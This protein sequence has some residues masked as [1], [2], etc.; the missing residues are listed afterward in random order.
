MPDV[1]PQLMIDDGGRTVPVAPED[2][3]DYSRT[4]GYLSAS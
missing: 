3:A 4:L 2:V 1:E